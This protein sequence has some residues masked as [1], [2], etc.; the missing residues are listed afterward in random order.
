MTQDNH[1]NTGPGGDAAGSKPESAENSAGGARGPRI[2]LGCQTITWG[3]ERGEK[4]DHTVRTA[5]AAGYEGL[6]IGARFLDLDQPGAFKEV[7][8]ESGIRLVA[9]HT[10]FNPFGDTNQRDEAERAIAFAQVT[11][12]PFLI[13]SGKDDEAQVPALTETLN[14]LGRNCAEQGMTLCYHN[15]WW[16]IQNGGR[17]LAEI[18]KSTDPALVSFCPDIGWIRKITKDMTGIL[19]MI[20]P[21]IRL[22]HLKDFV[23]DGMEIKDNETEFGGGIMD[24]D[25]VFGYLRTLPP[26]DL[27]VMAEHWKSSVNHLPPEESIVR[28]FAFLKPYI[29]NGR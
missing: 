5:A 24:F 1:K 15:H 18:A 4:R 11:H 21:R 6:E 13:L 22:A 19:R 23:A 8:D 16:E 17:I 7:L 3:K 26:G 14:A 29:T 20:E 2:H 25:E 9:L 10:G 27:W 12:T 28:N